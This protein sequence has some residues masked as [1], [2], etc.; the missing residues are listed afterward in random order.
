MFATAAEA[1][2]AV[3]EGGRP[4][5]PPPADA[6]STALSSVGCSY[7][8]GPVAWKSWKGR[9][10]AELPPLTAVCVSHTHA[11]THAL[12]P[13]G[14]FQRPETLFFTGILFY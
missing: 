6:T 10:S 9:G 1:R 5:L 12:T 11:H 8:V 7:D 4:R 2:D 3:R 13:R 14:L